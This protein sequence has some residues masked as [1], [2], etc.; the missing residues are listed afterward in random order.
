MDEIWAFYAQVNP[1]LDSTDYVASYFQF[2]QCRML[3][4]RNDD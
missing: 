2:G 3:L 4:S 1:W